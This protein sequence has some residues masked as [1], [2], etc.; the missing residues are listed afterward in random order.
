MDYASICIYSL[1]FQRWYSAKTLANEAFYWTTKALFSMWHWSMW[2]P[3]WYRIWF[4]ALAKAVA[5]LNNEESYL[6]FL[7]CSGFRLV[8]IPSLRMS[9]FYKSYILWL[10]CSTRSKDT[11]RP[12]A[13]AFERVPTNFEV[14]NRSVLPPDWFVCVCG[15]MC[16]SRE[17]WTIRSCR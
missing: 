5:A 6:L 17:R 4:L 11:S 15:P 7:T 12:I 10:H 8:G 9:F 16:G 2:D 14:V 1:T 3:Y 13:G